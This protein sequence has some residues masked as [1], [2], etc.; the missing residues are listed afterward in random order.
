[1]SW[2]S[3]NVYYYNYARCNL[4]FDCCNLEFL[5]LDLYVFVRWDFFYDDNST[6][7]PGAIAGMHSVVKVKS[8]Q[9]D[10][11]FSGKVCLRD[12]FS[13]QLVSWIG[14]L[15]AVEA[16][17]RSRSWLVDYWPL[18]PFRIAP[19]RRRVFKCTKSTNYFHFNF[20]L[21]CIIL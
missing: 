7:T 6:S 3:G 19:I 4:N 16:H 1:M 21:P 13:D 11:W 20:V 8:S 2:W 9:Y 10:V 5:F 18:I 17:C 14:F 15:C 12:L